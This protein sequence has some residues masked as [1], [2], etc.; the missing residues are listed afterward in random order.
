MAWMLLWRASIASQKL[1]DG[2]KKKD[3]A[4][5]EGQIKSARF[6]INTILPVTIG[7]MET[8]IEG[9]AAAVEISDAGFG[10]L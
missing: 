6:F 9:E 1:Q 2:A 4:F 7:K 8:I 5:Y 10:G 3:T